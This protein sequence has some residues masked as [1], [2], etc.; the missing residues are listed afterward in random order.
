MD[1]YEKFQCGILATLIVCLVV[2]S[3]IVFFKY[4]GV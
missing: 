3:V 1:K 2:T 4:A